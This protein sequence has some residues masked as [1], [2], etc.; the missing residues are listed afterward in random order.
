MSRL[1]QLI[2][3]NQII[4]NSDECKE[5][6]SNIA[7]D[8]IDI[9]IVDL[10][11]DDI[12]HLLQSMIHYDYLNLSNNND[13]NNS[14][15][16]TGKNFKVLCN[17]ST[18]S[19]IEF[20]M[21]DDIYKSLTNATIDNILQYLIAMENKIGVTRHYVDNNGLFSQIPFGVLLMINSYMSTQDTLFFGY[22]NR[23]LYIQT[24]NESFFKHRG[25]YDCLELNAASIEQITRNKIDLF[26]YIHC[27]SLIIQFK[28]CLSL[29][30]CTLN[31]LIKQSK[32]LLY[33]TN[34]LEILMSNSK[35]IT[36]LNTSDEN[37]LKKNDDCK[38]CFANHFFQVFVQNTSDLTRS[39][40]NCL[41]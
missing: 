24:Q 32:S 26:Q 17:V 3:C 11:N 31:L 18:A 4:H 22:C 7:P 5:F 34:W 37:Q 27:H 40:E 2:R 10:K 35:N 13:N 9:L 23:S 1:G 8:V 30:D 20:L 6:E 39:L 41:N 15:T 21:V 14:N 33:N 19:L 36:V 28:D 38:S 16:G 12:E 25:K 29:H